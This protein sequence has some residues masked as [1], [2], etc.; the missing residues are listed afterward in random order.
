[1]FYIP[2]H[3]DCLA[4]TGADAGAGAGA[5]VIVHVLFSQLNESYSVMCLQLEHTQKQIICVQF[6]HDTEVKSAFYSTYTVTKKTQ[7]GS[8]FFI[9][10]YLNA[11]GL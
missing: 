9:S 6:I 4:I 7:T 2:F 5:I 8:D 10:M 11:T 1:M 3:W